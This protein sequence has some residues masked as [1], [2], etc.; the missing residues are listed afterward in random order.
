MGFIA[1]VLACATV[2]GGVALAAVPSSTT[3]A[4]TACVNNS[5]GAVRLIDYQSGHRCTV[6]EHTVNWSK[7]YRYRSGWSPTAAYAVLDV[8][9][10]GGSSYLARS[11]STNRSPATNPSYWGLLVSRGATG[12]QGAEGAKGA[13][14]APGPQ[15]AQGPAGSTGSTGSSGLTGP[16]GNAGPTGAA[17]TNGT[18]GSPGLKGDAG[19][20]GLQGVQGLRGP[21]DGFYSY[22]SLTDIGGAY[23][24]VVSQSL[25]GGGA[26]LIIASTSFVNNTT[27]SFN[28]QCF[29]NG[30]QAYLT[31]SA[32]GFASVTLLSHADLTSTTTPLVVQLLCHAPG[33]TTN[34]VFSSNPVINSIQAATLTNS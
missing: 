9:T 23:V 7:G 14:G 28:V 25:P 26:Y 30:T 19:P 29:L 13:E 20:Q 32:S 17:G 6:S 1:G 33:G 5:T 27:T 8:V 31:V 11:G 4:F 10:S 24:V 12:P 15:G 3:G 34:E 18:N 2:G 22:G 21:S 16:Q